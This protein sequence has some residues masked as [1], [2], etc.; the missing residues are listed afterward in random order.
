MYFGIAL[1]EP[2][3]VQNI[4]GLMRSAFNFECSFIATV[5]ERYSRTAAD[6]PNS[7]GQVPYFHFETWDEFMH[8]KPR[9]A[10]LIGIEVNGSAN[11]KNFVHPKNSIYVFGGEDRTLPP[12]ILKDCSYTVRI[13]SRHCLN[14]ATAGAIVMFD[15]KNKEIEK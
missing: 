2:K 11:I 7:V 1:F 5:G 15:R 9:N 8:A 12:E 6:T 13:P 4:G 14:L 3:H 10:R